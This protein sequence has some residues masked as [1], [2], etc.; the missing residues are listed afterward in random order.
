MSQ[1]VA[2][3]MQRAHLSQEVSEEIGDMVHEDLELQA[4]SEELA[5]KC[6][7]IISL[8]KLIEAFCKRFGEVHLE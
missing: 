4:T 6:E 1:V 3:V 2:K 5:L 7:L 8:Y